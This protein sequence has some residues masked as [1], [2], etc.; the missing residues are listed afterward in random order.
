[1]II[2]INNVIMTMT[3]ITITQKQLCMPIQGPGHAHIPGVMCPVERE[4]FWTQSSYSF[5]TAFMDL[6]PL[7]K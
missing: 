5:W 7:L 6:E 3:S 2:V 1:M 4:Q